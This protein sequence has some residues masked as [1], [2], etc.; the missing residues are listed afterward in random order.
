MVNNSSQNVKIVGLFIDWPAANEELDEIEL[1]GS[2][3]WD[4]RDD[5]PPSDISSNWEGNRDI[6]SGGTKTLTFFFDQ[7]AQ[8]Y[9]YW[10]KLSFDNGCTVT[11]GG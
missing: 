5:T 1:D 10:L 11:G 4:E 2:R 3:I 8:P 7:D 9:P 6:P